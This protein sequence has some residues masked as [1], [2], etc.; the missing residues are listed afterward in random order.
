MPGVNSSSI[1]PATPHEFVETTSPAAIGSTTR[2]DA[3]LSYLALQLS[4]HAYEHADAFAADSFSNA[5]SEQE[6]RK[7]EEAFGQAA[8]AG[9]YLG[10]TWLT[11]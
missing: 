11:A 7:L 5:E 2:D 6:I 1:A 8:D 4:A 10:Q 9:F 3:L